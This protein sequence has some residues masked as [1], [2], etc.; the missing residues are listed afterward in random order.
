LIFDAPKPHSQRV[1]HHFINIAPTPFF[2]GFERFDD[3]VM[4][5]VKMVSGMAVRRR[6]TTAHTS[7]R[8]AESQVQPLVTDAQAVLATIRAR[9]YGP[10]LIEM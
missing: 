7:A 5:L 2:A 10:D 9:R 6:V 3:W 8:H 1:E 4:A